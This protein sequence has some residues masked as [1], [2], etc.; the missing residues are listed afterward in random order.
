MSSIRPILLL[1][2]IGCC[3]SFP[4]TSI[5]KRDVPDFVRQY[6]MFYSVEY[7]VKY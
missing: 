6:G 1:L 3:L 4:L 5:I 7:N 2:Y